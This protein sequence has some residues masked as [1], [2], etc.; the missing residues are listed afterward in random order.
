MA[1]LAEKG[2][3]FTPY[4]YDKVMNCFNELQ[5]GRVDAIVTDSLVAVDYVAPADTPFE[6]V[7]QGAADE[8]FGICLKKGNDALTAELDKALDALFAEGTM[9][10]ISKEIFGGIDMVSAARK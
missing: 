3:K 1:N 9:L 10:R 8:V 6:I 2:L 7:W 5:L 4:E